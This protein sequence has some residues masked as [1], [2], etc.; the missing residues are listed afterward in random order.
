MVCDARF[1]IVGAGI[2]GLAV[3]LELLQRFPGSPVL[4]V[5]KESSVATHQTGRNSGVVHSG[6]YYKPG[7]LKA[8]LCVEGAASLLRFCDLHSVPYERCGKVIVATAESEFERLNEL[9]HRG[10]RNGL[11]GLRMLNA[12]EIREIEPHAAGI[13]GIHVPGT[14]IVDYRRVAE[15]YAELIRQ[16]GGRVLLS[17]EVI[18]LIRN[19]SATTLET[20]QGKITAESVINCAGLQ[21][22]RVRRMTGPGRDLSIVPFRGEYYQISREKAHLVKG[23]IYPVPDPQFPFLGVHFT[24]R[25]G[26]EV[27][28][29]PNAVLAW[30]REGYAKTSFN[31]RDTAEF[32]SFPGFWR[33]ASR[34]WQMSVGEYYRSWNKSAFVRALQRLVPE[35][36]GED[37]I[38]GGAGVR[39]QALSRDG[40]L[41]DDFHIVHGE[42]IVHVCNVPSP[43]ATASLAI[44]KYISDIDVLRQD[45]KGSVSA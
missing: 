5:E 25:I 44:A 43:A 29:G 32:A 27:E 12:R 34:H 18:R 11:Q 8:S 19:G 41:I 16:A 28:A 31:L 26:G 39:A 33:M 24:K 45:R 42:G 23:L 40:K 21:S 1:A 22:D 4:V 6:I 7:S 9:F 14:A 2:V 13:R 10:Q 36:R 3:A 35:L 15:K 38:P 20:R 30:K 17:H 37:L